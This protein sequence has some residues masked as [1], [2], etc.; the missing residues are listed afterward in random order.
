MR[1]YRCDLTAAMGLHTDIHELKRS[2]TAAALGVGAVTAGVASAGVGISTP[3]GARFDAW[4]A[5]G[6][7]AGMA[8]MA[9]HRA[10]RANPLTLLAAEGEEAPGDGSVI[11]CAFS[12]YTDEEPQADVRLAMYAR[13]A[14]YHD[15]LRRRLRPV[16]A[17]LEDSGFRARICV[18]SAPVMEK[19]WA[20]RAG[21]GFIG[22]N[23][24]LITREA[25]SM[26]FLAEIVTDAVL[27]PDMP[28]TESCIGC[29]AC[30]RSCPG[31]AIGPDD[32]VD[33]R[34][35][36]SYLTIEH[37]GEWSAEQLALVRRGDS[38]C[39]YGCDICQQVCPHNRGLDPSLTL[40][41]LRMRPEVASLTRSQ[42]LSMN[43]PEFSR[44]FAGSAVKRAK[45]AG[46]RR[47]ASPEPSA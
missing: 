9:S 19:Y 46:L 40:P 23:S 39:I 36:L 21:V 42:V 26:V 14:D 30:A 31:G 12:Y 22:R 20:V 1:K 5:A 38:R 24:L 41:E 2:I 45:L 35:C 33:A 4:L 18:D 25:G 44:I 34:R 47:N 13:G 16:A 7:N 43:Q 29:G 3:A 27:P 37:R 6:R 8:Y 17:L 11:V 15:V 28:C 10:L 32:M